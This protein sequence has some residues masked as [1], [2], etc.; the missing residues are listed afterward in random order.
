L[1]PSAASASL[2]RFM[3]IRRTLPLAV[4]LLALPAAAPAHAATACAPKAEETRYD[5][6]RLLVERTEQVVDPGGNVRERWWT[7]W[8]P[9]GRR[10]LVLDVRHP[11][12][13]DER[14]LEGV[15]RGRFV[16]LAGGARLI[17][18]DAR[19]GRRTATISQRGA[20]RELRV[21]SHGHIA[22]LQDDGSGVYRLTVGDRRHDCTEDAGPAVDRDGSTFGGL[23]IHGER[24][25]WHRGGIAL[26]TSLERISC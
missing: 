2:A 24:L 21:S 23:Q 5:D 13:V 7:C 8:G 19:T 17:V 16:V 1:T 12:G 4:L 10:S 22:A 25:T 15:R 26:G 9:N 20:I 6:G 18:A 14:A 3:P 11:G